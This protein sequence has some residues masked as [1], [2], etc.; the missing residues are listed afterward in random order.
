MHFTLIELLVVIAII[1]ILAGMLL[2]ALNA[3]RAKA[4]LISCTG[5]QKQIA[6]LMF[7]YT[8]DN[9]DY[10][11]QGAYSFCKMV[12]QG[13]LNNVAYTVSAMVGSIDYRY[14]LVGIGRLLPYLGKCYTSK[15]NLDRA[16]P[17]PKVLFC[18]AAVSSQAYQKNSLRWEN[19]TNGWIMCTY[20]YM[21]PYSYST[22][23]PNSSITAS[24]SGKIDESVKLKA[25]LSIGHTL[26]ATNQDKS[27]AAHSGVR[28]LSFIGGDTFTL[29]H[30]DGHVSSKKFIYNT[31]SWKIFW[32]LHVHDSDIHICCYGGTGRV[33]NAFMQ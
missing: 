31:E 13:S 18:P 9:R 22:Y 3:A 24:N 27:I 14:P 4:R 1:A 15:R 17:V 23:N 5:N 25:F 16:M 2:P 26:G 12:G 10:L 8:G 21:D 7:Q 19:G 29:V 28:S 32:F 33:Q 6:L 11:P 20:G 30:A